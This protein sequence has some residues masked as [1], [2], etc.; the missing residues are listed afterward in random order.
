MCVLA[1]KI[2][3][4]FK[5]LLGKK[6]LFLWWN[7]EMFISLKQSFFSKSRKKVKTFEKTPIFK[8]TRQ[9]FK[10][11]FFIIFINIHKF[12]IQRQ[13]VCLNYFQNTLSN[14]IVYCTIT[15][16]LKTIDSQQLSRKLKI[17]CRN[18]SLFGGFHEISGKKHPHITISRNWL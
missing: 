14:I 4:L 16:S 12:I 15:G 7:Q 13:F 5:K 6:Y 10:W 9:M 3:T 17:H 1:I 11:W 8:K 18:I 2:W